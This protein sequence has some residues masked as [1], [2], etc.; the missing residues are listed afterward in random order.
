MTE[1]QKGLDFKTRSKIFA[2]LAWYLWQAHL[3]AV[4][5]LFE[6]AKEKLLYVFARIRS[7]LLVI[8]S[9]QIVRK[10][11][12]NS[13]L[14]RLLATYRRIW[15]TLLPNA[16]HPTLPQKGSQ[17]PPAWPFLQVNWIVRAA[18]SPISCGVFRKRLLPTS[19]SV[20]VHLSW[21]NT[22]LQKSSGLR[23]PSFA[24]GRW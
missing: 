18:C 23:L 2:L 1:I 22:K 8:F 12:R 17:V 24:S 5:R 21:A 14:S 13:R 16:P 10:S 15:S 3:F 19:R 9:G 11:R 4:W 6:L 20:C 7:W